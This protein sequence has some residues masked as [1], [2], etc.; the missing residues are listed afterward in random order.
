MQGARIM[1]STISSLSIRKMLE[2]R[3][4]FD[5]MSKRWT[6][7]EICQLLG[8]S[9]VTFYRRLNA[10]QAYKEQAERGDDEE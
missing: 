5:L 2:I 3:A 6:R 10:G 1:M 7:Q 4:I 9:E 8:I